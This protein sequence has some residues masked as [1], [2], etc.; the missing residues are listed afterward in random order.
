MNSGEAE[1]PFRA[2]AAGL[3]VTGEPT[4]EQ[5]REYGEYLGGVHRV[6][7]WAI[8]DWLTYGEDQWGERYDEAMKATGLSY[9]TLANAKSVA[10]RIDRSR[11]REKLPF[12][13][14]VEVAALPAKDADALLASAEEKG[15]SARE[16]RKRVRAKRTKRK[17][18]AVKPAR[19]FNPAAEQAELLAWLKARRESWPSERRRDFAKVVRAVLAELEPKPNLLK[20]SPSTAAQPPLP[21]M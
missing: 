11:R 6:T 5:W 14:H 9:G 21:G 2:T 15:W 1:S 10:T 12:S 3:I 18:A 7:L 4:P 20:K 8:G 16:L 13:A 19:G 17:P